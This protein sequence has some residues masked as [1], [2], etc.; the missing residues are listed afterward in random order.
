MRLPTETELHVLLQ[1][2]P[3][4][5]NSAPPSSDPDSGYGDWS[6]ASRGLQRKGYVERD[7]TESGL[8]LMLTVNGSAALEALRKVVNLPVRS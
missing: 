1:L 8:A 4:E 6:I 5:W 7:V 2:T 3:G